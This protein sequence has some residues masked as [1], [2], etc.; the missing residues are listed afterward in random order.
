MGKFKYTDRERPLLV[1]EREAIK[2]LVFGMEQRER[3]FVLEL[4]L[5]DKENPVK[6]VK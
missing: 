1:G 5:A 4:L 2:S 6:E 3:D